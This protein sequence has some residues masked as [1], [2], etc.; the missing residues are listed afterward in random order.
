MQMR[1]RRLGCTSGMAVIVGEWVERKMEIQQLAEM[2]LQT[3]YVFENGAPFYEKLGDERAAALLR[4]LR[5][6]GYRIVAERNVAPPTTHP[7]AADASTE[8]PQTDDGK[9]RRV[10]GR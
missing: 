3:G 6:E 10:Q 2:R 9:H 5:A 1:P 7:R 8:R 4:A